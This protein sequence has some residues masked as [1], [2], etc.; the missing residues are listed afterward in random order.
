[1]WISCRRWR[2]DRIVVHYSLMSVK[3]ASWVIKCNINN[4]WLLWSIIFLFIFTNLL[5]HIASCTID[6]ASLRD[7]VIWIV[8]W[9]LILSLENLLFLQISLLSGLIRSCKICDISTLKLAIRLVTLVIFS[10]ILTHNLA[11]GKIIW[12]LNMLLILLMAGIHTVCHVYSCT[13]QEACGF[14]HHLLILTTTIFFWVLARLLFRILT[15]AL[16]H[17]M[18]MSRET[19]STSVLWVW[20]SIACRSHVNVF[21]VVELIVIQILIF[22]VAN[23]LN[24][25]RLEWMIHRLD[26]LLGWYILIWLLRKEILRE[27]FVFWHNAIGSPSA[28]CLIDLKVIWSWSRSHILVISIRLLWMRQH[29]LLIAVTKVTA[30]RFFFYMKALNLLLVHTHIIVCFLHLLF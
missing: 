21:F 16:V 9:I 17:H 24:D 20:V 29:I 2:L 5:I 3:L 1:M 7:P 10:L 18:R 8:V 25:L 27:S 28:V 14:V 13:W 26:H 6:N 12:I 22:V 23:V 30:S 19:I 11:L 15:M 4:H